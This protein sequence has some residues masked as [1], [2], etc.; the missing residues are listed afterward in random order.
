MGAAV[1]TYLISSDL[2]TPHKIEAYIVVIVIVAVIAFFWM[3]SRSR[4]A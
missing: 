3:R 4:R 1:T 2:F